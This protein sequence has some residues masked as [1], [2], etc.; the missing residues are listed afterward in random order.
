MGTLYSVDG[1]SDFGHKVLSF[2][3]GHGRGCVDDNRGHIVLQGY[4]IAVA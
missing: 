4:T 2:P 3:R 1:F